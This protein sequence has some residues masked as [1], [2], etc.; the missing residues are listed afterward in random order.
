[1]TLVSMGTRPVR[2]PTMDWFVIA[3]IK[4]SLVWLGV[5]MLLGLLFTLSPGLVVYRPAHAHLNL[6]GFVTM[7]IYGVAYHVVPRFSG[8][9]LFSPRVAGW[10]WWV[11]NAGVVLLVLGF[12]LRPHAAAAAVPALA[13]GG[14]LAMAAAGMFIVNIWR[15]LD[16]AGQ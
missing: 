9:P 8:Y 4:A 1:M 14:A 10:S 5:G 7:M 16:G 12:L 2:G 11:A 6:L 13:G 15:T 3:F